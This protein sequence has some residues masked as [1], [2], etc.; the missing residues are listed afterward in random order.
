LVDI[1]IEHLRYVG[2]FLAL[3]GAGLGLPIP[4]E[5]PIVAA[6]VWSHEDIFMWWLA[7]PVCVAGVLGGDVVLYWV[8]RHWGERVLDWRLVRRV[9]SREREALLLAAYRDNGVK[10]VFGARH[11]MGLRAAAF[12]T[13]GIARV[14]FWKF[15]AVD[16]GA[17]LVGV[18]LSFGLGFVFADQVASILADVRRV[19][20]WAALAAVVGVAVWLALRAYRRSR[21]P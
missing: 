14:P 2:L 9:L 1:L 6:G 8:G 4:E 3:F 7:L 5:V 10:I 19:E 15:L 13:A 21:R 20:R 18:P 17:A 11:V 12:L 16:A